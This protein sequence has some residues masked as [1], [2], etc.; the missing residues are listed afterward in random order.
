MPRSFRGVLYRAGRPAVLSISPWEPV[1]KDCQMS[2][3]LGCHGLCDQPFLACRRR[4]NS[5]REVFCT[6]LGR[7]AG[8]RQVHE[9]AH[10]ICSK[11]WP[12]GRSHHFAIR[13][14]WSCCALFRFLSPGKY[15]QMSLALGCHGTGDPPFFACRHRL[16]SFRE[17]VC[18]IV[19][20]SAGHCQVHELAHKI[21]SKQGGITRVLLHPGS[22]LWARAAATPRP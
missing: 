21:R 15:C 14:R 18:T 7:S 17:V 13:T 19:G 8:H 16:F 1:G 9:L 3:A 11:S 5:L 2:L 12:T 20:R 6:V 4:L 10:T 22:A